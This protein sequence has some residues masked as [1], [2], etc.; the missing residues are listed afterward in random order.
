[1]YQDQPG[2]YRK[3]HVIGHKT[4]A[5]IRGRVGATGSGRIEQNTHLQNSDT[6]IA[7]YLSPEMTLL[8]SSIPKA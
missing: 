5:A 4:A 7:V 8:K 3:I 2:L 1:M 6:L